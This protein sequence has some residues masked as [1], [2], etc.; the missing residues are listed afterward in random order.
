MNFDNEIGVTPFFSFIL[1]GL[2][3]SIGALVLLIMRARRQKTEEEKEGQWRHQ[4]GLDHDLQAALDTE[5][6]RLE[7]RETPETP[8]PE[9]ATEPTPPGPEPER[10]GGENPSI[11]FPRPGEIAHADSEE[12]YT[13]ITRK[14]PEN[15]APGPQPAKDSKGETEGEK[16]RQE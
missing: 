13:S 11:Q 6:A 16:P 1:L 2:M 9:P 10:R 15:S 14:K 8:T 12:S 7:A 5:R 4:S 3:L